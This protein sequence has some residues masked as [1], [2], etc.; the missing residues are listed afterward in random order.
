MIMSCWCG[1]DVNDYLDK[2]GSGAISF[3]PTQYAMTGELL[4]YT[5]TDALIVDF[6]GDELSDKALGRWPVRTLTE[7]EIIVNKTLAFSDLSTGL[8]DDRRALLIAEEITPQEGYDFSAQ[9]ERLNAKLRS[10][11]ND[12]ANPVLWDD[13]ADAV[14]RVYVQDLID[15]G[16]PSPYATARTMITD[17]INAL[18]GQTVTIF[19]GHGSPAAWSFNL[20]LQSSD[21]SSDLSNAGAPTLMMPMACYTTYYNETHTNT[22]AHQLLLSG[23]KGAVAIH[24]AATLSGYNDNEAMGKAILE[25]QLKDGDTL[26]MAVERR[27]R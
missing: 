9:M 23:D 21:V 26:G 14:D 15:S 22:L 24:A 17:G 4:Q 3:I 27:G 18:D 25:F 6:D 2:A 16:D 10:F 5:P 7:L 12:P 13:T 20:L 8:F 1:G 19:G 11:V